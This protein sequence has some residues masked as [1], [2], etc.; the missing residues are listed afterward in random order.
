MIRKIKLNTI[1]DQTNQICCTLSQ[2][3]CNCNCP[4]CLGN[5]DCVDC[6]NLTIANITLQIYLDGNVDVNQNPIYILTYQAFTFVSPVACFFIDTQLTSL[7]MGR[8]VGNVFVNGVMANNNILM[9]LG[10]PFSACAPYVLENVG[11]GN[12]M[13]V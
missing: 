8:Y 9:M 1:N 7:S 6:P 4:D 3:G 11:T 10:S 2:T 13:Q 12:D 5:V